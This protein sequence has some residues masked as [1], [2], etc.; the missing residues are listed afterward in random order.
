M[1]GVSPGT[2]AVAMVRAGVDCVE[3]RTL[4]RERRLDRLLHRLKLGPAVVAASDPGLVRDQNHRDRVHIGSSDHGGGVLAYGDVLDAVQVIHVLHHD[5][6]AV[7]KQRRPAAGIVRRDLAP[8]AFGLERINFVAHRGTN[9]RG[10]AK[11]HGSPPR[12]RAASSPGKRAA[13]MEHYISRMPGLQTGLPRQVD[14]PWR[15]YARRRLR[16]EHDAAV[17][18]WT[19]VPVWMSCAPDTS[20]DRQ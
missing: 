13:W 14:S 17:T 6:V 7:E 10:S 3:A 4:A 20:A 12:T 2:L 15:L 5:A 19:T 9:D 18:A 8:D 16:C 1:I 11:G